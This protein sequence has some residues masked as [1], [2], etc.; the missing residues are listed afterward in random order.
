MTTQLTS[1]RAPSTVSL[2]GWGGGAEVQAQLLRPADSDA[3]RAGLDRARGARGAIARGMGRS[4]GDAAQLAG[5]LVL[6]L[7]AFKHVDLDR[8]SGIVT[9]QA[10]ITIGEL[11]DQ[12]VPQGW[13]VLVAPAA[14]SR[15][16]WA[17]P[18]VTRR[19]WPADSS[20]I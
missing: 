18:T 14:R 20:S 5:G 8:Q 13:I 16:G 17:A 15:A 1:S 11:L 9:A 4:Y 2:G 12:V 10:G 19:N 7:T 6:D 3:L